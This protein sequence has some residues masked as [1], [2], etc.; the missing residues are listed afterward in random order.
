MNLAGLATSTI[1]LAK[2]FRFKIQLIICIWVNVVAI[3]LCEAGLLDGTHVLFYIGYI[4]E[5][6]FI[7]C[8]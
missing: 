2:F 6:F 8:L 4:I 1:L 3:V 7:G 5:A